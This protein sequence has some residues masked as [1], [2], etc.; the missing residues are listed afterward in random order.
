MRPKVFQYQLQKI[1]DLHPQSTH[2]RLDG[3]Q[4]GDDGE[5]PDEVHPLPTNSEAISFW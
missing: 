4:H 1:G 5:L 3:D 2:D